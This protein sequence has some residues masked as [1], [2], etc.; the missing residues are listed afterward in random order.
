[1]GTDKRFYLLSDTACVA[2]LAVVGLLLRLA[3][4][5]VYSNVLDLNEF[6]IPWAMGVRENPFLAYQNVANL[7]YPP[8]FPALLWFVSEGVAYA[9]E[10]QLQWLQ[11]FW[12]KLIPILFDTALIVTLYYVGRRYSRYLALLLAGTWAVNVSAIFNCAFWGQTDCMMLLLIL[13]MVLGYAERQPVWGTVAFAVGCLCKLQ[14]LY[15]AP[16][17]LLELFFR[18]KPLSALRALGI[19]ILVGVGGWLPFMIGAGNLWL[20][21]EIYFGGFDTYDFLN[22]NAFNVYG[23]IGCNWINANLSILGGTYDPAAG[24]NLGGFT[25]NH[26][27]I[28]LTVLLLLVVVWSY[29]YARRHRCTIPFA[30]NALFLM[31]G[32][33]ML[34]TK[35]H[36]RYQMPALILVLLCFLFCR[37]SGY[38]KAFLAMTVITFFNQALL[39]FKFFWGDIGKLAFEYGQ[40]IFSICNVLLF[41]WL[42]VQYKQY[43]NEAADASKRG[44]PLETGLP[45]QAKKGISAS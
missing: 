26:F 19:G 7:D 30:L 44:V 8:L 10:Q 40:N 31:N 16:L 22:L 37:Q 2:A 3:I 6:N 36:E 29:W 21:F 39:T 20:P 41:L 25:F 42:I 23:V 34:T 15:F 17:V 24:M 32:I 45:P 28:I 38:F 35:M 13:L 12:I 11:M 1:M 4:G 18:Y 43:H 27:S 14:M 9:V 33:F 5:A